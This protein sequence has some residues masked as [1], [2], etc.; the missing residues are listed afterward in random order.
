MPIKQFAVILAGCGV[1]DGA[2]IHEATF[3]M[4][5]IM[6]YGGQYT[7]FAPDKPQHHVINHRTGD[8]MPETRNVL[9]EAARIARGKIQPLSEYLPQNFDALVMPGGF[10]VAKNFS[11]LAFAGVNFTVYPEIAN[12]INQTITA[13]KPIAALCIAPALFARI[14]QTP[15]LTLGHKPDDVALANKLGANHINTNHNE[16]VIDEKYKLVSTPCYMLDAT[17]VEIAQGADIAISTLIN[18]FLS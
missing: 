13:G 6:K 9:T 14:L 8:V 5:S 11:D 1:Y 10:G 4:Y 7:L 12:A 3:T 2:E 15:T 18:K 16:I 17:I